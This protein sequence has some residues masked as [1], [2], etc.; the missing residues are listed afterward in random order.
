MKKKT[1][2][3]TI[4]VFL[5]ILL[6]VTAAVSVN[7][8]IARRI[9]ES[10][11]FNKD[12]SVPCWRHIVPGK[13]SMQEAYELA[14][15]FSD[16]IPGKLESADHLNGIFNSYISFELS[17]G[18]KVFVYSIEDVVTLIAFNHDDGITTFGE[19][20]NEFGPPEF[21]GQSYYWSYGLPV[22]S[23]QAKHILFTAVSRKK[24]VTYGY[25]AYTYFGTRQLVA[26]TSRVTLVQFFDNGYFEV[27]LRSGRLLFSENGYNEENLRSW[28]GYGNIFDLYPYEE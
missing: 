9:R 26:K 25:D 21:A 27:L 1:R 19:C 2:S 22:A 11:L 16:R 15:L 24:G 23:T 13:T 5:G 4:L 8:S 28:I 6:I 3:F 17:N 20:I 12:C 18:T 14:S 10:S 7:Q